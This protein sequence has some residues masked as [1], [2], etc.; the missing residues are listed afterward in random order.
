MYILVFL[1]GFIIDKIS[2]FPFGLGC[3]VGFVVSSH[4]DGIVRHW[5]P[6]IYQYATE[7][8]S[9]GI[10]WKSKMEYPEAKKDG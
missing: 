5:K 7:F 8:L 3:V 6:Q 4:Y 1:L 9:T 10:Q 2:L